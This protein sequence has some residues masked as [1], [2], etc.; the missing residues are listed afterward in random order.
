MRIVVETGQNFSTFLGAR[1]VFVTVLLGAAALFEPRS[2]T[3]LAYA[4]L[5]VVNTALSLG[6]WEWFRRRPRAVALRWVTLTGAVIVDTFM[7]RVMDRSGLE[8]VFLYFFSISAAGLLAGLAGSLWT[9]VLSIAGLLWIAGLNW[10]AWAAGEG[11]YTFVLA[12]NFLLTAFLSSFVFERLRERDRKHVQTLGELERTRLDTRTVLGA[13]STGVVLLDAGRRILYCNAAGHAILGGQEVPRAEERA[14]QRLLGEQPGDLES[15]TEIAGPAGLT[16]VRAAVTVLR[17][18]DGGVR[19]YAVLLTDLTQAR[20]A[21]RAQMERERLAAIGRLSRDLAH[22]IRNPL[23]TVRGCVEVLRMGTTV[24]E[25]V[26]AYLDLALRES[27]RLNALLRDFLTFAHLGPPQKRAGELAAL[28]RARLAAWNP[29]LPVEDA[30]PERVDAQFDDMQMELVVD[31][32]LLALGEWAEGQDRVRVE[33]VGQSAAG[34]RFALQPRAIPEPMRRAAFQPFSGVQHG[35]SG[36][37]LPTAMRAVH[38]HG[39]TLTLNTK[40]GL[41][42]WFELAL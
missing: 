2:E 26:R 8:F 34:I 27:D 41:G 33:M 24:D 7:L 23:A 21:E 22:E 11:L 14:M 36:L 28:I 13:L 38:A 40:P 5:F 17:E 31:A 25:T 12:I 18:D 20:E 37:A 1:L 9:A 6:C 39:G 3:L 15:E 30:L 16:P 35:H 32:I 42:T 29:P 19:G 10:D 4:V